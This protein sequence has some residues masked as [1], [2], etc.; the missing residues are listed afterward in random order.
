M[1]AVMCAGLIAA[2]TA[3]GASAQTDRLAPL[4][5]FEGCWR[6][7]FASS[8]VVSDIRCLSPMLGGAYIRDTHVIHGAPTPYGGEAIYAYDPEGRRIAVTY[9]A[10]DGV[11]HGFAEPAGQGLSFPQS[12]FVGADGEITTLRARWT[13]DGPDK[14]IAV[15]EFLEH[16]RW[17]EHLHITYSR[18]PDLTPPAQ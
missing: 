5:F 9:Y 3:L 4:H 16:G 1:R 15:A 17:V 13:P 10:V 2:I 11:E 18:A 12:R 6:G 7:A 14:F 8:T